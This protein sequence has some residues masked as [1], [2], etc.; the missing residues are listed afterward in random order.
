MLQAALA[1]A[2]AGYEN[3]HVRKLE[4]ERNGEVAKLSQL[5]AKAADIATQLARTSTSTLP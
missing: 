2:H 4:E 3:P 5:Q 1:K